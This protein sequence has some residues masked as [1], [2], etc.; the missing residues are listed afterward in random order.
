VCIAVLNLC[1]GLQIFLQTKALPDFAKTFI[2]INKKK[3]DNSTAQPLKTIDF[4]KTVA[5][6]N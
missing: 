4:I 5:P 1:L 3:R 2:N 6:S